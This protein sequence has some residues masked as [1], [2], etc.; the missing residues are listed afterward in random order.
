MKNLKSKTLHSL[1]IRTL[2]QPTAP[3]RESWTKAALFQECMK[4]RLP[5]AFDP[6][7]NLWV[8]AKN[9]S[10]IRSAKMIFVAHLDHP[11][12]IVQRFYRSKKR[13]YAEAQWLGGGP[14]DIR[15]K[16]VCLFSDFQVGLKMKGRVLSTTKGT[17]SVDRA[18]IELDSFIP[19][20]AEDLDH[21][22]AC[23]MYPEAPKG[24]RI[25]GDRV[26]TKAADDLIGA[27]ALVAAFTAARPKKGLVFCLTRAEESGFHGTL[28]ILKHGWIKPERTRMISIET[29]S[30][31]PGAE[32][33]KGPVLRL[34][35]RVSLFD[36]YLV[37]WMESAAMRLQK[38]NSRFNFQK[39]VMDGG[40]CEASAFK[41][42][43]FEVAGLSTPLENYHN[44]AP[45]TGEA[46]AEIV[47][48]S[49][50]EKLTVLL[51]ELFRTFEP[52]EIESFRNNPLQEFRKRIIKN[53]KSHER[54][55]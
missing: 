8:G 55:F 45:K 31:R 36:H 20:E 23:L 19:Y 51:T 4:Q 41:A 16:E 7:G 18:V 40:S 27:C 11:G 24:V 14:M 28:E 39:R 34:G 12:F 42:F 3:F 46:K 47:N 22:G 15:N 38:K 6:V 21:W 54:F 32:L 53:H 9:F 48:L 25:A 37:E 33:G 26:I 44:I 50:V 52:N 29:S 30:W 49:D 17:R 35:D 43:G 10:E 1:L 5:V 13:C 2:S